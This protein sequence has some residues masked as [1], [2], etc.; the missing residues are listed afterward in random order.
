MSPGASS[1]TTSPTDASLFPLGPPSSPSPTTLAPVTTV[2]AAS[3]GDIPD[4]QVFVRYRTS[5]GGWSIKVPEG[6][7]RVKSTNAVMFTDH[8]NF[9]A[10]TVVSAPNAPT[11]MSV[12]RRDQAELAKQKGY[13]AGK[14]SVVQRQAG[15]AVLITYIVDNFINPATGKVVSVANERYEFWRNGALVT[16]TLS[17]PVGSDNV[18]SWR[19]VTDSFGWE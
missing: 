19:T 17:T 13:R 9:I 15:P 6:W 8:V 4:N 7:A 3:P 18:D 5:G 12:A 1:G 2:E 10:V 14:V 11:I 16:V